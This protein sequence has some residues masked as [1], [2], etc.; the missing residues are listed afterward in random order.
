MYLWCFSYFAE[1]HR[2]LKIILRGDLTWIPVFGWYC[3]L[4]SFLLGACMMVFYVLGWRVRVEAEGGGPTVTTVPRTLG[5]PNSERGT[6]H[7]RKGRYHFLSNSHG[8]KGQDKRDKRGE[9]VLV[10]QSTKLADGLRLGF[11]WGMPSQENPHPLSDNGI[12]NKQQTTCLLF[13]HPFTDM[14]RFYLLF[15]L[16]ILC[17]L[18]V[19]FCASS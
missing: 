5:S 4:F 18:L 3:F 10:E 12:H 8:S 6:D 1:K 9:A 7:K 14:L 16:S 13:L 15:P 2:A 11:G 17:S 19:L